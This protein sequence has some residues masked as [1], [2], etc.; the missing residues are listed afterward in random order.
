MKRYLVVLG[1]LIVLQFTSCRAPQVFYVRDSKTWMLFGP[2]MA[3]NTAV[4]DIPAG[5]CT[6]RNADSL[7]PE[8][9]KMH[10]IL[11]ETMVPVFSCRDL[12]VRDIPN[13]IKG[14]IRAED[15]ESICIRVEAGELTEGLETLCF[16]TARPLPLACFIKTIA[17][18]SGL[19]FQVGGT[20]ITFFSRQSG[21]TAGGRGQTERAGVE[22]GPTLE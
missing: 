8:D 11:T 7:P 1:L 4:G 18:V 10:R 21:D 15:G 5:L 20:N 3:S 6:I 19:E 13:T 22:R 17:G 12:P 14:F 2:L 9:I 16:A